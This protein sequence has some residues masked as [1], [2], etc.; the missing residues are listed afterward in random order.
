MGRAHVHGKISMV[1]APSGMSRFRF[2]GRL[3]YLDSIQL[4]IADRKDLVI[5]DPRTAW[6]ADPGDRKKDMTRIQS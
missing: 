6:A 4:G 3:L 1:K 2:I 5:R